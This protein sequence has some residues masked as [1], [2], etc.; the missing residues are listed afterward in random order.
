M[1]SSFHSNDISV[2]DILNSISK[3]DVQL[4]DFQRGWVW[5]N[6]RIKELIAIISNSH[7]VGAVMFLEY[8]GDNIRFKYRIFKGVDLVTRPDKLVLDG[9]QRLTSIFCAMFSKNVVETITEKKVKIK[10]FYY[11]NIKDCLNPQIDRVDAILSIPE[12]RKLKSNFGKTVDLDLSTREK[13]FENHMF[14]LNIVYDLMAC[15]MWQN[16]YQKNSMLGS[17]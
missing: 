8:G 7:P 9:Q 5:D 3:A 1:S 17:R 2:S 16:D 10:R 13:E 15:V 4:P 14:L 12:E 11:L 6:Y